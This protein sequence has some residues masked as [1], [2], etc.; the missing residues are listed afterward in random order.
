MDQTHEIELFKKD[1]ECMKYDII[2][3]D[4]IKNIEKVV[5]DSYHYKILIYYLKNFM[6]LSRCAYYEGYSM[7]NGLGVE[8]HHSPIT[9]YEIVY[10]VMNKHLKQNGYYK[11]MKVAKEVSKLHY[12][13]KVGLVPLNPTAHKLVHSGNLR[14]HPDIVKG[15]WEAFAIEYQ[16]YI[17]DDLKKTLDDVRFIREHELYDHY[18]KILMRSETHYIQKNIVSL[19]SVNISKLLTQIKMK[20]LENIEK[21]T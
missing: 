7:S 2:K 10:A 18:P 8:L 11:I 21:A 13:F 16:D 20:T 12:Q 15:D 17:S 14:I 1:E 3:K 19:D 4:M 5:R 9:L 6:D